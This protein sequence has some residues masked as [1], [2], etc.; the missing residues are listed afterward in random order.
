MG[1]A[2]L[3]L[4]ALLLAACASGL[5]FAQRAPAV[6]RSRE[7][8]MMGRKFENN[9]MKM[10]KTALAYAKKAS[11][12]GKQ[13]V[14]AVKSGGDDPDANLQLAAVMR[15]ANALNVPKDVRSAARQRTP[16][17]AP[18]ANEHIPAQHGLLAS[19]QLCTGSGLG[20]ATAGLTGSGWL[21]RAS[22][23]GRWLRGTSHAEL[24]CRQPKP[25]YR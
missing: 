20:L 25:A 12:I 17:A 2:T 3:P 16:P 7:V 23:G 1:L 8:V 24:P 5:H 15:E 10:A 18:A 4:R 13:V 19:R 6:A 21:R 22:Y 14:I 9:K 11:Y